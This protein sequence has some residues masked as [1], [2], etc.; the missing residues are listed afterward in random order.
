MIRIITDSMSDLTQQEA[1]AQD[2]RIL[3]LTVRF[4]S[5]EFLDGVS[6]DHE[7]FYKR[8][9]TVKELPGHTRGLR[10]GV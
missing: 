2:F 6:L 7:S 8:L 9:E 10:Q 3:P 5:E 4:G 1:A